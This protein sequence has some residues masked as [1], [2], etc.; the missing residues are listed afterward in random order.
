MWGTPTNTLICPIFVT[1]CDSV[2]RFSNRI[3]FAVWNVS[4]SHASYHK[5]MTPINPTQFHSRC[6]FVCVSWEGRRALDRQRGCIVAAARQLVQSTSSLA[7]QNIL[8]WSPPDR[9]GRSVFTY[10]VAYNSKQK[11]ADCQCGAAVTDSWRRSWQ[12]DNSLLWPA[13]GATV[14]NRRGWLVGK[15]ANWH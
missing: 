8:R 13:P 1:H 5:Y 11:R 3:C 2:V 15:L 4:E 14:G 9:T 6:V 10:G 12:T 7:G